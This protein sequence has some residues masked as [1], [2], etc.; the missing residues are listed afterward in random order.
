M[1]QANRIYLR[2]LEAEDLPL[3]VKWVNDPEVRQFLMFDYPLS[4]SKTKAWFNSGLLQSDKVH[5]SIV[6][7][8]T[9]QVIGMTGLL[10]LTYKHGRAQMYITIG[11]EAYRG[12]GLAKEVIPALLR[13]AFIEHNLNK[14][15]LYTLTNNARGRKVYEG[16]GFSPDGCLRKHYYCVGELQDIYVHSI[17]KEEFFARYGAEAPTE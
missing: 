4:L 17:L 5:F 8:A 6:D 1:L 15:Y 13:Y 3:R 7:K 16:V 10:D 2:L 9:D 11:E 12:K 14:V